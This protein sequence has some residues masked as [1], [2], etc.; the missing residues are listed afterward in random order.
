M[1]P[2]ESFC[3]HDTTEQKFYVGRMLQICDFT[4]FEYLPIKCCKTMHILTTNNTLQHLNHGKKCNSSFCGDKKI[5]KDKN[6]KRK[7]MVLELH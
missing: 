7:K 3:V 6:I 2:T 4:H 1:C 5:I